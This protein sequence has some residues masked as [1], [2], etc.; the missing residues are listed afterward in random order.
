MFCM[1]LL[2]IVLMLVW[3]SVVWYCVV[4]VMVWFQLGWKLF[5]FQLLCFFSVSERFWQLFLWWLEVVSSVLMWLLLL[6]LYIVLLLNCFCVWLF[7][8]FYLFMVVYVLE[9]YMVKL[10]WLLVLSCVQVWWVELV[11]MFCVM[12]MLQLGV[13]LVEQNCIVLFRLLV[14]VVF[15]ELMFLV[16]LVLLRFFVI[17][18]WLMCRLFWLLQFMLFSGM[19]FSVKLRWFWLKLC[20]LMWVDY[21]QLLNGLVDLKCMFGLFFSIFSG[22][23][24]GGSIFMFLLVMCCIWCDLFW[25]IIDIVCSCLILLMLVVVLMG[26]IFVVLGVLVVSVFFCSVVKRV[27]VSMVW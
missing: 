10:W 22:L 2:F 5:Q 7:W 24:F 25:L 27:S 13:G 3:V 8:F 17:S 6:K 14:D 19:L 4:I 26:V 18:V 15:S 1:L 11:L 12:V 9:R 20:R 23:L 16:S 21:L